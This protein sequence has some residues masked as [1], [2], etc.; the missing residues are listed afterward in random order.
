MD[1]L[2]FICNYLLGRGQRIKISSS[3]STWPKI[4]YGVSQGSI[5]GALIFNTNTLEMLFE[6]KGV[7]F[8]AYADD[9]TSYFCDKNLG[10]L[11]SK[12]QICALKLPDGFSDN[13]IKMN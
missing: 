10:A 3:F 4:E 2:N 6:E 12:F 7:N 5:L 13:Y 1:L 9:N 8:A 11:L